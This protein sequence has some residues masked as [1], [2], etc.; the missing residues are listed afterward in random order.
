[1]IQIYFEIPTLNLFVKSLLV[2]P[3]KVFKSFF[4]LFFRQLEK[5]FQLMYHFSYFNK[6]YFWISKQWQK[7]VTFIITLKK[8]M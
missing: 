2:F 5:T 1:M 6:K 3:G 8:F 7:L 4:K